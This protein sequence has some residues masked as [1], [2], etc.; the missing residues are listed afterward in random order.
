MNISDLHQSISDMNEEQLHAL[1]RNLRT[2][3]RKSDKPLRKSKTPKKVK[4]VKKAAPIKNLRTMAS[5]MTKEEKLALL[6]TL[7]A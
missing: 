3:R 1:I 5:T 4:K 2:E 6:A 7:E